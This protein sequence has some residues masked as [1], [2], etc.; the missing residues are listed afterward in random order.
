MLYIIYKEH[1]VFILEQ[2]CYRGILP[3]ANHSAKYYFTLLL[4]FL[5]RVDLKNDTSSKT[6]FKLINF[7]DIYKRSCRASEYL[8]LLNFP[9]RYMAIYCYVQ[10]II[11]MNSYFLMKNYYEYFSFLEI[12]YILSICYFFKFL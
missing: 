10:S 4:D 7:R 9:N 5:K 8:E 6:S 2:K 12:H 1:L 3:T 11:V